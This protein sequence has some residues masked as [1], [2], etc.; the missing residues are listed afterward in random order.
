MITTI[1]L[2]PVIALIL[3]FLH[4]GFPGSVKDLGWK[5]SGTW[6]NPSR[7]LQ[8]MMYSTGP[9]LRGHVVGVNGAGDKA[10]GMLVIKEM[11][12][13]PFGLWSSGT[14]VEPVTRNETSVKLRLKNREVLAVQFPEKPTAEEW[15]LVRGL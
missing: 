12:I 6:T 3:T 11:T 14:F 7:D 2:V 5:M 13:Q 8:I 4:R 15:K 9:A 1:L 10:L